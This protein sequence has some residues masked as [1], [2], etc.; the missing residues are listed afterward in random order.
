MEKILNLEKVTKIYGTGETQVTAL[1]GVSLEVASG[2]VVSVVGHSGSGK[3][4]LLNMMGALDRPTSGRIFLEEEEI[5][6]IPEHQLYRVRREKIGFI[7]QSFHLIPTLNA[8]EN[9]LAP[10]LPLGERRFEERARE[11]LESVGLGAR[12][13][14]RPSQLSGGEM[15]RVAIARA[16]IHEPK[17][18]LADEPTGNLDS[19]TGEEI[20]NLLLR[21]NKEKGVTLVI[22]THEPEIA[23]KAD[24]TVSIRDGRIEPV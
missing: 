23:K 15:Q 17:L 18:I 4:T 10:T 8:L 6:R 7:F 24:R 5:S 12:L 1:D 11:L 21:L 20:I 22:V 13:P 14:H 9:V 16:L 2:E 3:T 19:K